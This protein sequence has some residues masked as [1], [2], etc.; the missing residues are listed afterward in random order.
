MTQGGAAVQPRAAGQ[1]RCPVCGETAAARYT[2]F[3]S[4][5]CADID[6]GRWLKGNYAIPA[7][8]QDDDADGRESGQAEDGEQ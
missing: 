2:P 5:R 1:G 3:C 6:L 7:R 8:P 4:R